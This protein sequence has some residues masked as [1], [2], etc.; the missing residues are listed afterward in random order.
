MPLTTSTWRA[1]LLLSVA[2]LLS[3]L[4]RA[5]IDYGFVYR[6]LYHGTRPIGILT[7]VYLAFIAGWIW[8][9]LAASHNTRPAMY[10]LLV[11]GAITAL[12]A[13]GTQVAFCPFPCRTAWPLGQVVIWLNLLLGI[14]AVVVA[15]F[16]LRRT[17]A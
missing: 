10:V 7:L 16:S 4:A 15:L 3:F 9:L 2:T 5:L 17:P 8:A 13:G 1:A 12:H 11:Y 14:P 6:E